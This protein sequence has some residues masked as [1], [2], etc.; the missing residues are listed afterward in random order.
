MTT[1]TSHETPDAPPSHLYAALP[2]L[3]VALGS[4]RCYSS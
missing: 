1:E 4:V 3:H 2:E